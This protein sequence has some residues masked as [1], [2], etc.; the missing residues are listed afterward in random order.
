MFDR[1][2]LQAVQKKL[3]QRNQTR[4][5]NSERI[6]QE[7]LSLLRHYHQSPD[8]ETLK[9]FMLKML[10]S[11]QHQR[12]K[13]E[14][15]L[16]LAYAYYALKKGQ[17]AAQYLQR[18]QELNPQDPRID[19]LRT[20]FSQGSEAK[21]IGSEQGPVEKL[22][23]FEKFYDEFEDLVNVELQTFLETILIPS[24]PSY[25]PE[26]IQVIQQQL[27]QFYF[28]SQELAFKLKLIGHEF[29]TIE[30]KLMLKT[31]EQK[32]QDLEAILILSQSFISLRTQIETAT[33]WVQKFPDEASQADFEA[34]LDLCDTIADQLDDQETKGVDHSSLM[35]LYQKLIA[36]IEQQQERW[37]D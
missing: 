14:P 21:M 12:R 4:A 23:D 6:Y 30:L 28:W 16:M 37:D 31:F 15:Y 33:E 26:V 36:E 24:Q 19:K 11:T 35:V 34:V 10:E 5:F 32:Q 27:N 22:S 20:F 2:A 29:E 13:L 7:G 3:G 8:K 25:D 18:A 1:Q 9:A 17:L